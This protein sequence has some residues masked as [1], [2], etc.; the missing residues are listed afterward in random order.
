MI[1]RLA[2]ARIAADGGET[3]LER[4]SAVHTHELMAGADHDC[5]SSLPQVRDEAQLLT[6]RSDAWTNE[7][8]AAGACS[9]SEPSAIEI[10]E[11]WLMDSCV[12]MHMRDGE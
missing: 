6:E 3:D 8:A 5:N 11:Y 1:E 12:R 4:T 2:M 9:R 7:Q 10:V